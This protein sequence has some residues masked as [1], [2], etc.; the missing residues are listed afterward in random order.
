MSV[1]Q[2]VIVERCGPRGWRTLRIGA[3]VLPSPTEGAGTDPL[4]KGNEFRQR[5][6]FL[7]H[8]EA[9]GVDRAFGPARRASDALVGVA[10]NDKQ[11]TCRLAL[12]ARDAA[13]RLSN[14]VTR[15]TSC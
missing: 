9:V 3:K 7:H 5:L 10:A 2:A 12:R 6:H 1:T 13:G 4:G 14:N 15:G 11:K 8:S